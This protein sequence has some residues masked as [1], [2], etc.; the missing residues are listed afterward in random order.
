MD[1]L[2]KLNARAFAGVHKG[3]VV[4]MTAA[5]IILIFI[6]IIGLMIS[7]GGFVVALLAY[8]EKKD[9]HKDKK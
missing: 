2:P 8:L 3:E 4:R 6:G 7:F 5:D 1:S 9:K